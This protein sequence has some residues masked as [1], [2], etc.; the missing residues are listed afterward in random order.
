MHEILTG[1]GEPFLKHVNIRP[2]A[3]STAQAHDLR[4]LPVIGFNTPFILDIIDKISQLNEYFTE[5]RPTRKSAM[6]GP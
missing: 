5:Y 4:P 6:D 2:F 3:P 1:I